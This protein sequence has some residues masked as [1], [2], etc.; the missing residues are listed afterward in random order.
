[1]PSPAKHVVVA[2]VRRIVIVYKQSAHHLN[3]YSLITRFIWQPPQ[4]QQAPLQIQ[5]SIIS[6]QAVAAA[7]AAAQQQY[8][9]VPVSMVETGRQMLLTVSKTLSILGH[10][11]G[12]VCWCTFMIIIECCTDIL[13]W[14]ESSDGCD[15]TILAAITTAAHS[16]TTA[17]RYW[18]LGKTPYRGQFCYSTGSTYR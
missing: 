14:W 16:A 2:Q 12:L 9:A 7:A 13:A 17:Q 5:S 15:R 1:M 11:N 6:Q 18:R 10:I 4:A 8:A 3:D